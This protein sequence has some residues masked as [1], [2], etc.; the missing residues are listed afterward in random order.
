MVADTGNNVLIV[1]DETL[2]ALMLEDL[3]LD[4]GHHV[5]HAGS[6]P[7]AMELVEREHF[8][9]AIL[10]INLD[11]EDVF[12]LAERLRELRTPF[13]FASA[14]DADRIDPEFRQEQLIAKPYTIGQVEQ[15][16]DRMLSTA[17]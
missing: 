17:K 16:L 3:L 7:D 13:V 10:D 8:D 4:I 9:A 6:L 15:S 14:M 1:E 12:P 11:G 2:L 5:M